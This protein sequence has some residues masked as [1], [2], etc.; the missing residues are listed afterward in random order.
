M[1]DAGSR[2]QG[3]VL[4]PARPD[5]DETPVRGTLATHLIGS[6]IS[7]FHT[8][9]QRGAKRLLIGGAAVMVFLGGLFAAAIGLYIYI[10]RPIDDGQP[11]ADGG[12]TAIVTGR[13]GPV[14]I[15]AYLV[16]LG[17]G[18]FALVDAGIDPQA[19]AILDALEHLGKSRTDVG[20]IL[21]THAHDDHAAGALAF[22]HAVVYALDPDAA[23]IRRLRSHSGT[24]G[25]TRTLS[26]GERLDL[27]GTQ[28]DVFPL[29]GHTP[30][31]AAY[32]VHG[33]LFLGDTSQG[34]RNGTLGPNTVMGED[35]DR[36]VRSLKALASR[37]GPR[38]ADIRSIA[39][40]HSGPLEGF[41]PLAAWASTQAR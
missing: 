13:F 35:G 39:F 28:V 34:L 16:R 32:L 6:G 25:A 31:S 23:S 38:S 14:T 22:P 41:A 10:T 29:P 40:G 2:T 4:D 33:V 12:V 3:M 27:A 15:P 8:H 18:S 9:V 36:H 26:G 7:P 24:G 19:A 5:R 11:I 20:V 17:D 21:M 30:G 1:R 37:L